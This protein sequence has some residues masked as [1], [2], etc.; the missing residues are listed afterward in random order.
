M[1]T[2]SY[3]QNF[4]SIDITFLYW[5]WWIILTLLPYCRVLGSYPVWPAFT[6]CTFMS[7]LFY[8]CFLT[9]CKELGGQEDVQDNVGAWERVGVG[10]DECGGARSARG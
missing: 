9:L 7:I 10:E 4:K 1:I 6:R 8:C 2:L 3:L 5:T